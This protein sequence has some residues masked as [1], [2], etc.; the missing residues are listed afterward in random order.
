MNNS[1]FIILIVLFFSSFISVLLSQNNNNTPFNNI[2]L[3]TSPKLIS[4][5]IFRDS[6]EKKVELDNFKGRLIILNFWTTWCEPCKKEMPSLDNL[7]QNKNFENLLIFPI[8]MEKL[9]IKKTKKFFSDLEI[10]KLNI[11]FD[12]DLSLVKKLNLR[13]VPTT[14]LVNKD[15]EEFSRILGEIDFT[16]KK[17]LKWLMQYQ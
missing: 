15:G 6:E 13:G 9:N 7:Y 14:V 17:F 11:F 5:V 10:K 4:P 3:H 2:I 8:N 1:K 16:D 12:T